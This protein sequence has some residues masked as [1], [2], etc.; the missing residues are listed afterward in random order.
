MNTVGSASPFK[1]ISS[2]NPLRVEGPPSHCG[3]ASSLHSCGATQCDGENSPLG[4]LG[5]CAPLPIPASVD[6]LCGDAAPLF[7]SRLPWLSFLRAHG[8]STSDSLPPNDSELG[9][10]PKDRDPELAFFRH[11][12]SASESLSPNVRRRGL[13]PMILR[14]LIIFRARGLSTSESL[15]QN[16]LRRWPTAVHK[17]IFPCSISLRMNTCAP[18]QRARRRLRTQTQ[19]P[20]ALKLAINPMMWPVVRTTACAATVFSVTS[21]TKSS[22]EEYTTPG[23]C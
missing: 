12:L 15:S 3:K 20:M 6:N 4:D 16:D 10:L 18:A 9:L 2:L 17:I 8:L 7:A 14:G 19:P 13:R 1:S 22:K 5:D 23:T 11:G 21:S